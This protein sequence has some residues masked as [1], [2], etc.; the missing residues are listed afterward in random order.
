[1]WCFSL[2][3]IARGN[4]EVQH[5]IY[6]HICIHTHTL[7]LSRFSPVRLC[8]TPQTAAHQA[9]LSLGFSRQEHWS[10]LPLPSPIYTYIHI[11]IFGQDFPYYRTG[12]I[13]G[14]L[15][16]RVF[17]LKPWLSPRGSKECLTASV[18]TRISCLLCRVCFHVD[19]VLAGT[20]DTER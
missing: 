2:L 12:I 17:L 6:I 1:M 10:G 13:P 8:A 11:H 5:R 7:L 3:S 20:C 14:S 4:L 9:P 15:G 18:D 16:V 19:L